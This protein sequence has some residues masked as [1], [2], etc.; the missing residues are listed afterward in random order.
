MRSQTA[1]EYLILLA[2][3]II[4]AVIVVSAM[5][6]IPSIGGGAIDN[7]ANLEAATKH[8]GVRDF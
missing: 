4:I 2:V 5:G 7:A 3:V 8:V 1:T 6:G